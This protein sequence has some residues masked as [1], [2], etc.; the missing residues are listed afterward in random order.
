MPRQMFGITGLNPWNVL[1]AMILLAW[2]FS[3]KREKLQ[4]NMPREI[5]ILLVLYLVIVLVG[6]VRM[7]GDMDPI[8]RFYM[9]TNN[10]GM[11]TLEGLFK[12]DLVNSLKYVLPGLLL[13]HGCNSESRLRLGLLTIL[14]TSLLLGLQ[15]IKWMPIGQIADA[16]ALSARALRV[17]DRSVGYHRVDLAA[18]M[19]GASWAFMISKSMFT[20]VIKG[21][22]MLAFGVLLILALA[23]TGGRAGYA[24]WVVLGLI[25]ATLKWR[26]LLITMPILVVLVVVMI[27]AVRERMLEGFSSDS[28]VRISG[29]EDLDIASV[30]SGRSYVWPIVIDRI[31]DRPFIGYGRNGY[32]IS[33]ASYE[34]IEK[35]GHIA[36]EFAHPHN[37]YLQLLLDTGLIGA[38]PIFLFFG[39]TFRRS[40]TLFRL[41][42]SP[43]L[44][45][46]GGISL[47][48]VGGQLIASVGS[49]SFYPRAGVVLMWC[50]IGLMYAVYT[51][52]KAVSGGNGSGHS[53]PG[54]VIRT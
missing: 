31:E 26:K 44:A 38:I 18:I 14:L 47:V 28:P 40:A 46:A 27:P 29:E 6:F 4:W 52:Q 54:S 35:T 37:A 11:P 19:A 24:T 25:V 20:D 36:R 5:N 10:A 12:D 32:H 42:D 41:K 30:T 3:R 43:L 34:L 53:P 23:L 13:F 17:L 48:M 15:I 8:F 9:L 50:S 45:T 22:A 39:L 51:R 1:M 21:N 7:A 2:F 33:G 49:Q 16:E